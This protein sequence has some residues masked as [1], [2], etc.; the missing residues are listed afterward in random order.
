[1]VSFSI[2]SLEVKHSANKTLGT[3]AHL[4]FM[5]LC[6]VNNLFAVANMLLGASAA[7]TALTGMHIIAATFLLPVV[8]VVYTFVGGIKATYACL[9]SSLK[10]P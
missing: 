10:G 9:S 8:V 7:I 2:P 6:L 3:V 4:V 5:F 1:M